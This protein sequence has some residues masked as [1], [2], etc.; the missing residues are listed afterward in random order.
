MPTKTKAAGR[1][2]KKPAP[3]LYKNDPR[4]RAVAVELLDDAFKK[5]EAQRTERAE[6]ERAAKNAEVKA[7]ME[8]GAEKRAKHRRSH[9]SIVSRLSMIDEPLRAIHDSAE[10]A[11]AADDHETALV[12]ALNLSMLCLKRLEDV[13]EDLGQYR[14]GY[15]DAWLAGER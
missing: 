12:V 2:L 8:R 13:L 1:S 6:A 10:S 3:T 15:A 14:Q 9:Q 7:V 11:L 4:V 5:S